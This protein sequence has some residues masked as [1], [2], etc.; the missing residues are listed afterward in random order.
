M[1][2]MYYFRPTDINQYCKQNA[3]IKIQ[4]LKVSHSYMFRQSVA[5]FMDSDKKLLYK[6][7]HY[8][9]YRL[10]SKYS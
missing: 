3:H 2:K 6:M 4:S 10:K 5:V 1:N 8:V 9:C 7:L